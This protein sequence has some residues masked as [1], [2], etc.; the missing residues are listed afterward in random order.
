M[1]R[2][3][4]LGIGCFCHIF[5]FGGWDVR[6]GLRWVG[7]PYF[8]IWK[9]PDMLDS[10][11]GSYWHREYGCIMGRWVSLGI[12]CFCPIFCFGG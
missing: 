5:C 2:W 7:G 9:A 12:G 6:G 4:S 1:G 11:L 10:S 8:L 3:V